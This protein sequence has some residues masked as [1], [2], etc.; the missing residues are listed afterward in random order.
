MTVAGPERELEDP[1]ESAIVLSP[2]TTAVELDAGRHPSQLGKGKQNDYWSCSLLTPV[3]LKPLLG[4]ELLKAMATTVDW[5]SPLGW[6]LLLSLLLICI[7]ASDKWVDPAPHFQSP[8][9]SRK[10]Q[11][12]PWGR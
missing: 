7:P 8:S 11:A 12:Y 9:F 5:E 2:T 1:D 3:L 10:K 4:M 6:V